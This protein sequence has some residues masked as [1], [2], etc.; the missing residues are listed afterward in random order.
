MSTF[1][2]YLWSLYAEGKGKKTITTFRNF[3]NGEWKG[4]TSF[5]GDLMSAFCPDKGLVHETQDS[6][7]E[8]IKRWNSGEMPA[9]DESDVVEEDGLF[10]EET[11]DDIMSAWYEAYYSEYKRSVLAQW[12]ISWDFG[13][14]STHMAM[15]YPEQFIPYYFTAC[16]NVVEKI[17]VQFDIFLPPIPAKGQKEKRVQYLGKIS[18][19]FNKFRI[20]NQLSVEELWAFLYD[21]APKKIGG[22]DW[23]LPEKELK[24]PHNV[25]VFG[26]SDVEALRDP[27][28]GSI[29]LW[30]GSPEMKP[31]DIAVLYQWKP[32]SSFVSIWRAVSVG[33]N[34]PIFRHHRMVCY[35]AIGGIP[36]V[37]WEKLKND[38]FLS[39]STLVRQKMSQM[40]G[41][42]LKNSEYMRIL[43]LAGKAGTLSDLIPTMP[44]YSEIEIPELKL[45][46][47]VEVY[48]LEGQLLNRLGWEEED[49]QRQIPLRDGRSTHV[50]PDY[51]I[52]YDQA[53]SEG[54]IVLE[55]KL[56]I[57]SEK[58]AEHD[59]GQA[60]A[61]ARL[62]KARVIVLVAKEGIWIAQDHDDFGKMKRYTWGELQEADLFDE[63]YQVIG[64]GKGKKRSGHKL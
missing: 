51:V 43:E 27:N 7:R 62:L 5:I 63:V 15:T 47:D 3:L 26:T 58:Q 22:L 55:A 48:L 28:P 42:R 54:E 24:E 59:K 56:T 11:Y 57:R 44:V 9:S 20:E 10:S 21:Y 32:I 1:N 16:F 49:Y 14:I 40:D 25:F 39:Q 46:R 45:E 50:F 23:V 64:K 6:I 29:L 41:A 17:A 8:E 18:R 53:R 13:A 60:K 31:G 36:A 2:P 12:Y 37:S 38:E 30:Q 35:S 4:Y 19:A 33:F 61:Y 34:D 52:N